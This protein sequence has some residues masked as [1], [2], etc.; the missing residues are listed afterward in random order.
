MRRF[1]RTET[2]GLIGEVAPVYP[3]IMLMSLVVAAILTALKPPV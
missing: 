1:D 2:S 3:H